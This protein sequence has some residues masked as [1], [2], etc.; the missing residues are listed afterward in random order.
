MNPWHLNKLKDDQFRSQYI[1]HFSHL[2]KD[3]ILT[4]VPSFDNRFSTAAYIEQFSRAICQASYQ[5]L[6]LVWGRC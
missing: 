6:D 3:L 4:N 2:T 1:E 5:S